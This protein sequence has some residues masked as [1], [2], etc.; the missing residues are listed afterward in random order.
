MLELVH[1]DLAVYHSLLV[2]SLVS[3]CSLSLIP[4]IAGTVGYWQIYG[5]ELV[6]DFLH[7][8]LLVLPD[9]LLNPFLS[10]VA[11][12]LAEFELD[13]H[14][15]ICCLLG[16]GRLLLPIVIDGESLRLVVKRQLVE[17]DILVEHPVEAE[18]DQNFIEIEVLG[19]ILHH[20]VQ[21]L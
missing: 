19:C 8:L 17:V 4:V 3:L 12:V 13:R 10:D 11:L 18:V 14:C 15:D 2:L 6:Y 20:P 5:L 7:F 21:R 16:L 9:H 1:S